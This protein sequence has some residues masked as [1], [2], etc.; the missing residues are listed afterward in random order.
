MECFEKQGGH[1]YEVGTRGATNTC[2]TQGLHIDD[3]TKALKQISNF[4]K[5]VATSDSSESKEKLLKLMVPV[6]QKYG[7]DNLQD[8]PEP[9]NV[10]TLF[11][12]N[13]MLLRNGINIADDTEPI[14]INPSTSWNIGKAMALQLWNSRPA[15]KE[16]L[17]H[18]ESPSTLEEYQ[19]A[20][21]QTLLSFFL[22][23]IQ[24][25]QRKKLAVVN[26]K[27]K[28]RELDPAV[29]KDDL[30]TRIS[31]FLVSILL[32]IS[33]RKWKIWLTNVMSSLCRRPKLMHYLRALLR[34]VNVVS[35]THSHQVR[36]ERKQMSEVDPRKRL[37]N[38]G[39]IWN[40]AVIDNIDFTD[41]TFAYGNIFDAVR[42]SS[43]ATLRMVFQF[44]MPTLSA[45][46]APPQQDV[47]I[48]SNDFTCGWIGKLHTVIQQLRH[49][50]EKSFDLEDINARIKNLI[51]PGCNI[52]PPNVVI[53]EAGEAPR[54]FKEVHASCDK[55]LEDFDATA[56]TLDIA[57]DEAIFRRLKNYRN[58]NQ[59]ARV[60]LGQWHT[61]KDMCAAL[62]KIFSGYGLFN[63]AASLGARFLDKFEKVVDYPATF[64]TLELVWAAV[65]IAIQQYLKITGQSIS[66]IEKSD[67][68]VL[69]VWHLFFCWGGWLKLHKLGIRMG[70]FDLQTECLRAF[71]PLFPV[72]G[73]SNYAE[74]VS[75]FLNTLHTN[76]ELQQKMRIAASINLTANEHYLGYDEALERFGVL[77]IKQTIV[78]RTTD[79]ENLMNNIRS[80][81]SV[82]EKLMM[83]LKEFLGDPSASKGSKASKTRQDALW[84]TADLLTDA[85]KSKNPAAHKLFKGAKQLTAEGYHKLF[86]CYEIGKQRI[87]KLLKQDVWG[88]EKR[89]PKGNRK[90]NI[91]PL[92]ATDFK[93]GQREEE[94]EEEEHNEEEGQE[95]GHDEEEE[96]PQEEGSV[97]MDEEEV[98]DVYIP[99]HRFHRD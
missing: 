31:V 66:D 78:G 38:E 73:K 90:K 29:V 69:K 51:T 79:K 50:D 8:A 88:T 21:P 95:K 91:D 36:V 96:D 75:R 61:S 86:S 41:K 94:D 20:M 97:K 16:H 56:Q 57:C 18:L 28:Q 63:L 12:I 15:L 87:Y 76:P 98:M 62:I 47:Q 45:S 99:S 48:G 14:D 74:S 84:K 83:L 65:G 7:H 23:F 93:R 25:I 77:F 42:K 54:S 10:P 19:S 39:N 11:G 53:L 85:L 2:E 80:A 26:K 40:L 37:S 52:E 34:T 32:T 24:A 13:A 64:Q 59:T 35:Y 27:R 43:H 82:H 22:G 46:P 58:D 49:V 71:A 3:T 1:I 68:D 4:V 9:S 70:D 89:D 44:Q 33:F 55:Y 17:P 81:Q 60:I 5:S 92:S 30:I 6:V 72:A 67:N